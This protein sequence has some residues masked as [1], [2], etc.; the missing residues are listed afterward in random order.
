MWYNETLKDDSE[1]KRILEKKFTAFIPFV[2]I[3]PLRI[4]TQSHPTMVNVIFLKISDVNLL[5]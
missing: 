5:W 4:V 1:T 2:G 3:F